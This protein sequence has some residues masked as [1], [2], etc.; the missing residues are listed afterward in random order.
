MDAPRP[1]KVPSR[2][3]ARQLLSKLIQVD[4]VINKITVGHANEPLGSIPSSSTSLAPPFSPITKDPLKSK[5]SKGKNIDA[6]TIMSST[7]MLKGKRPPPLKSKTMNASSDAS[8]MDSLDGG[9]SKPQMSYCPKCYKELPLGSLRHHMAEQCPNNDI[10]CPEHDCNAIFSADH[11]KIHLATE[12]LAARRKKKLAD[13]AKMRKAKEEEA[14]RQAQEA[15]LVYVEPKKAPIK[16][17]FVLDDVSVGDMQPGSRPESPPLPPSPVKEKEVSEGPCTA[18]GRVIQFSQMNDHMTSSCS[19][20]LV[21]CPNHHGGCSSRIPYNLIDQHLK[22]TC[23]I[24]ALKNEMIAK[25][26]ARCVQVRCVGCG[27][28]FEVK[29][30]AKHELMDCVQRKVPCRNA[31]LG[32]ATMVRQKDR[33]KHEEVDGKAKIRYCLYLTGEG[34]YLDL[35]ED[36]LRCPW[37]CEFWLYR[38]SAREAVKQHIRNSLE[39]IPL[40][41][42][43]FNAEYAWKSQ[44]D[45]LTHALKDMTLGVEAREDIMSILADTVEALEDAAV[46]STEISTAIGCALMSAKRAMTEFLGPHSELVRSKTDSDAGQKLLMELMCL[47]RYPPGHTPPFNETRVSS[48]ATTRPG[49]QSRPG[50][51]SR[52]SSPSRPDTAFGPDGFMTEIELPE[53][54]SPLGAFGISSL[55]ILCQLCPDPHVVVDMVPPKSTTTKLM[56]KLDDQNETA[57]N[58]NVSADETK[59]EAADGDDSSKPIGDVPKDGGAKN[60]DQSEEFKNQ[61]DDEDDFAETEPLV[62]VPPPAAMLLM[63]ALKKDDRGEGGIGILTQQLLK[64]VL[65]WSDWYDM[66]ELFSHQM[67]EDLNA[68]HHLRIA[69]GIIKED[70]KEIEEDDSVTEEGSNAPQLTEEELAAKEEARLKKIEIEENKRRKEKDKLRRE[71]KRNKGKKALLEEAEAEKKEH[72]ENEEDI[73]EKTPEE[74][75]REKIKEKRELKRAAREKL[76]PRLIDAAKSAAGRDV[77][78]FTDN[79][80]KRGAVNKICLDMSYPGEYNDW[81]KKKGEKTKYWFENQGGGC[82]GVVC[83]D[84]VLGGSE[85]YSFGKPIPREKWVHISFQATK[86]PNNRITMIMD[87]MLVGQLKDCAFALPMTTL[88]G[89]KQLDG[90]SGC[91]LDARIWAKQRSVSE[92]RGTMSI[93]LDLEGTQEPTRKDY[94]ITSKGLVA[95][96]T[97]E[98]GPERDEQEKAMDVSEHR[99][100]S[101]LDRHI[102]IR[103][104]DIDHESLVAMNGTIQNIRKLSL[105][106]KHNF[107]NEQGKGSKTRYWTWENADDLP[108]PFEKPLPPGQDRPLPMPSYSAMGLCLF[109]LKRL[110]LAQKGR[111]LHKQVTCPLGCDEFILKKDLRMHLTYHCEFR[112]VKCRHHPYCVAT[113]PEFEREE[114]E[115]NQCKYIIKQNNI[116]NRAKKLNT[117]KPCSQCST[118]VRTRD[119]EHH[120]KEVCPH[121]V[122]PCIH[123]DC[124]EEFQAHRLQYHLKYECE[125]REIAVRALLVQRARERTNYPRDWGVAIEY[126]NEDSYDNNISVPI[127][128]EVGKKI[129]IITED[130]GK[131]HAVISIEDTDHIDDDAD[132]EVKPKANMDEALSAFHEMSEGKKEE[133][134]LRA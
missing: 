94:D 118:L 72:D 36:D 14:I 96:W 44:M 60:Q 63:Q 78:M 11:L 29:H 123:P 103:K 98:D 69:S 61:N 47:K 92:T 13:Q 39:M 6:P 34:S 86:E 26:A 45:E 124:D 116:V 128:Q 27:K 125:S 25:A 101:L 9:F 35:R 115:D 43:A 64:T 40:F 120:D 121:R 3:R 32:C 127:E 57:N 7:T 113:F 2:S 8:S 107:N 122:V 59:K 114:H 90:F 23:M 109:E 108:L 19:S 1:I 56:K 110:R 132:V 62:A 87:G 80:N 97:F 82:P 134:D 50:T 24:E 31:H 84:T 81:V 65:P 53:W 4:S 104:Y 54:K 105:N 42:D 79:K 55:G 30:L 51:K 88:A 100:P 129:V 22:N 41:Y 16:D 10:S 83:A 49:T 48:K 58:N 46:V 133:E 52:P 93:L 71:M 20:R 85:R 37:T 18:C 70:K 117:L 17:T 74:I 21:Y 28:S 102:L 106:T 75:E 15:A 89:S 12:C 91:L 76:V 5:G 33:H 112:K 126:E 130:F 73:I 68:L 95:W 66:L 67:N 131:E 77:L 119:K 99:A 111:Q 38:P